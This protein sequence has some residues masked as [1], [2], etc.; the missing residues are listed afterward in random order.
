[1]IKKVSKV[2]IYIFLSL[3]LF[4]AL[5]WCADAILSRI[6]AKAYRKG[7]G[8]KY[9]VYILSN[10]V[11]TDLV[12]PVRTDLI[13]WYTV[14]PADNIRSKNS[15]F[16]WVSIGWGDKGFYLNTPE[17][18]DLKVSTA[19][20]AASGLGETALHV[21]YYAAMYE[22]EY[23]YKVS[24]DANQFTALCRY[25]MDSLATDSAKAPILIP[26]TAV[27]GDNDAFYEAKGAYNLFFSC[28][29]WAN[30]ALKKAGM[31]AGIWTVFDRG[32]LRH[33]R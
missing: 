8:Q 6:P 10:G 4:A 3:V 12:L 11:H 19:L 17:W 31:P 32:I 29:T 5:Y 24:I 26:T 25:I 23:C 2:L 15:S 9:T 13:D 20:L 28:N 33:Y 7:E 14:F 1:M 27:Y 18:K 21:T 30:T 16:P 22:N